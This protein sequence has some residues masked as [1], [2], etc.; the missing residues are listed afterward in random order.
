MPLTVIGVRLRDG[1]GSN[2]SNT[3]PLKRVFV[4]MNARYKYTEVPDMKVVLL[5]QKRVSK[6]MVKDRSAPIGKFIVSKVY[7]LTKLPSSSNILIREGRD[8]QCY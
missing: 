8:G 1:D 5:P 4:L 3:A 7:E 6:M 2:I